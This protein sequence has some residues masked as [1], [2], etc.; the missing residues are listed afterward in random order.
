MKFLSLPLILMTII[1]GTQVA[2][3]SGIESAMKGFE[4]KSCLPSTANCISIRAQSTQGSQL[5]PIQMLKEPQVSL[6]LNGCKTFLA[7][8][9]G[10]VDLN[11]NQLVL[12]KKDNGV[13]TEISINLNTLL[14]SDLRLGGT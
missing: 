1:A 4:L 6:T 3:A 7:A 12:Y 8:A 14:R 5:R 2:L 9:T 10:Y 11:E 13:T